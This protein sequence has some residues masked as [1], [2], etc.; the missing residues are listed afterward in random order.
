MKHLYNYAKWHQ[1]MPG[2]KDV[3]RILHV[4]VAFLVPLLIL[5]ACMDD[6]FEGDL[7]DVCPRIES[8]SPGAQDRVLINSIITASFNKDMK[9]ESINNMTF[10]V[11]YANG[12]I[13]GD[14]AY[15]DKT[16]TF[17][18]KAFLPE[19]SEITVEITTE[20]YDFYDF[21]IPEP[22]KWSFTTGTIEDI[23]P[24][25]VVS[26][27]PDDQEVDVP[28]TTHVSATFNEPLDTSSITDESLTLHNKDTN[29]P[30]SG[31]VTYADNTITFWPDDLLDYDAHFEAVISAGLTDLM[32]N[33]ME[34]DYVWTF[35]TE[36]EEE[37]DEEIIPIPVNIGQIA[38][39]A[40][41]AG[42]H[43]WNTEGASFIH[44][45][46]GLFP[47]V[48]TDIQGIDL[49]NDL[50]G[51]WYV[52]GNSLIWGL[53]KKLIRDKMILARAYNEAREA[54]EPEPQFL[55]GDQGGQ[56]LTPGIYKANKLRILNGNLVLDAGGNP[57]A[58]WIFQV[59]SLLETGG[60][61]IL[62]GGANPDNIFWQVGVREVF[63]PNVLIGDNTEFVG[64]ILSKQGISVGN[65]ALIDGRLMVKDGGV[66]LKNATIERP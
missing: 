5:S 59:E 54:H 66:Y 44:G 20:V 65:G 63:G 9:P 57:H 3:K 11:S 32:G 2:N 33:V 31:A 18:P 53:D 48:S 43:I 10:V 58:F 15:S 22:Y 16:V 12:T 34:D 37:D 4:L 42:T 26:T 56:T 50:D 23:T 38:N 49:D 41:L 51:E 55:S 25:Y 61:I 39:Y 8:H 28:V 19:Q 21:T 45:D 13:E 29:Q 64:T 14:I 62:E 30:V 35:R 27:V 52:E 46:L 7:R 36:E 47:G 1:R 40:I 24:P 60:N 17:T 6:D